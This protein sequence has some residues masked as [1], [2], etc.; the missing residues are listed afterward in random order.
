MKDVLAYLIAAQP[1]SIRNYL[2]FE[3][4]LSLESNPALSIFDASHVL[5]GA[6]G[7]LGQST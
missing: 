1:S 4:C 5:A 3:S 6:V 2:L 7:K